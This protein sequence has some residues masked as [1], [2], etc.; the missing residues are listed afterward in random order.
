MCMCMFRHAIVKIDRE[1]V[2]GKKEGEEQESQ[3]SHP[4]PSGSHGNSVQARSAIFLQSLLH[5]EVPHSS[6]PYEHPKLD[7]RCI[8]WV[9]LS[10]IV[11]GG[12]VLTVRRS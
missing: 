2:D 5:C 4:G 8:G 3:L 11:G 7:H 6:Q 1:V 9:S 12:W 10:A